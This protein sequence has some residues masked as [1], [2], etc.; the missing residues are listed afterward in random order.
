MLGEGNGTDWQQVPAPPGSNA[1]TLPHPGGTGNGSGTSAG[2][3]PPGA[4]GLIGPAMSSMDAMNYT[5]VTTIVIFVATVV[6]LLGGI[7]GPLVMCRRHEVRVWGTLRTMLLNLSAYAWIVSQFLAVSYVG[8]AHCGTPA[9]LVLVFEGLMV[10]ALHSQQSALDV[11]VGPLVVGGGFPWRLIPS[12]LVVGGNVGL[13]VYILKTEAWN[14]ATCALTPTAGMIQASLYVAHFSMLITYEWWLAYH[15]RPYRSRAWAFKLS[16]L[17][18][19]PI[20]GYFG[21]A[22]AM[23]LEVRDSEVTTL[24][25]TLFSEVLV[26]W[27]S[28]ISA[29]GA[30][31]LLILGSC[32]RTQGP[33]GLREVAP[34]AH[35]PRAPP[36]S[37]VHPE[38]AA[39]GDT[40]QINML[41]YMSDG[42][43]ANFF[44]KWVRRS[45]P[46][47]VELV[48]L[49]IRVAHRRAPP[50]ERS[51]YALPEAIMEEELAG[52]LL[53]TFVT[54]PDAVL[55]LSGHT[56]SRTLKLGD[57]KAAR[58]NP[59]V[60]PYRAVTCYGARRA[61]L[62]HAYFYVG[63]L[64]NAADLGEPPLGSATRL[65]YPPGYRPGN[66]LATNRYFEKA[67]R[68]LATTYS[69]LP[70]SARKSDVT[71]AFNTGVLAWVTARLTMCFWETFEEEVLQLK[72]ASGSLPEAEYGGA[73]STGGAQ[74]RAGLIRVATTDA[75]SST[76]VGVTE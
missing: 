27:C 62:E 63:P 75:E 74:E 29:P 17:A 6:H 26:L 60:A 58:M 44:L 3:M 43:R 57:T 12:F 9:T 34:I 69:T 51:T 65:R 64:P 38:T 7:I 14:P 56:T 11:F 59:Q 32:S 5:I 67:L 66:D 55:A 20:A 54:G 40:A 50:R 49:F 52:C 45:E 68:E 19:L 16:V 76:R 48:L 21:T 72:R 25:L 47:L 15:I 39:A 30:V 33:T 31:L 22:L 4:F 37:F 13:G 18:L 73:Q 10:L 2:S 36:D 35:L 70:P 42:H 8:D 71:T 61:S 1:S 53:K 28:V 46:Y 23:Q 41:L 24:V